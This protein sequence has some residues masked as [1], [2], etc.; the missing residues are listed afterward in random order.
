MSRQNS[1]SLSRQNSFTSRRTLSPQNS[2][3]SGPPKDEYK[4]NN[5]TGA[6]DVKVLPE[7]EDKEEEDPDADDETVS[8]HKFPYWLLG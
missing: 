4:H 7:D 5:L 8:T 3:G 1:F 2:L 6:L